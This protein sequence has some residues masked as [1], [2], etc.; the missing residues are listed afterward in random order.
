[1][2]DRLLQWG[3]GGSASL[4][5]EASSSST[6]RPLSYLDSVQ[7][8]LHT[9]N[10]LFPD[11]QALSQ[12]RN[13]QIFPLSTTP[14]TS[15]SSNVR[16]FDYSEEFELDVKDVRVIIMQDA[17]GPT[18]ASLL[19]DSHPGPDLVSASDRS[20]AYQ[21]SKATMAAA[22]N[23]SLTQTTR[24]LVIQGET[25]QPRQGAFDRRTSNHGRSQSYSETDSQKAAR[26]YREELAAFSSCI[27]GNSELMAYKGTSTKVHVVPSEFQADESAPSSI[28]GEGR[29]PIGLSQSYSSQPMSPNFRKGHNSG[30]GHSR[31]NKKRKVLITRL[32]PVSLAIDGAD[33]GTQPSANCPRL[34]TTGFPFPSSAEESA[35]QPRQRRTPMYA[36]VLV[37][38]IPPAT[39]KNS[40]DLS[41][42]SLFRRESGSYNDQDLFSSSYNST[43][44]G[45]N[46]SGFGVYADMEEAIV[47]E[48][49]IDTLTEHWDVI[50]RTLNHLQSLV[51]TTIHAM[52]KHADVASP[53]SFPCP[54]R[55]HTRST[56]QVSFMSDRR[57]GELPRAK[58]LKS[59]TK[60][61]YLWPNCLAD[62]V[63]IG[64]EVSTARS[65]II[66]GLSAARVITGQGRWG[67]W[68]D[69]AIWTSKWAASSNRTAFFQS[70]LTGFLAT[71]TDWI[72]A[73]CGPLYSKRAALARQNRTEEDSSLPARTIIISD[74]KMAARRLVFLLSAF[75]P[76]NQHACTAD[77]HRASTPASAGGYSASPPMFA[78]PSLPSL[79][80]RR[81]DVL[82]HQMKYQNVSQ[83]EYHT[84]SISQ[85]ARIWADPPQ[86]VQGDIEGNVHHQRR[87]S[88]F[89]STHSMSL[90]M[91]GKVLVSRKSSAATTSTIMPESIA[92]HFTSA[93]LRNSQRSRPGSTGSAATDDLK[94]SLRRGDRS[95]QVVDASHSLGSGRKWGGLIVGFWGSRRGELIDSIA[96]SQGSA[97][98]RSPT[99]PSF[100]RTNRRSELIRESQEEPV[101]GSM[102]A[103]RRG[104]DAR[105]VHNP[106]FSFA[107]FGGR[108]SFAQADRT[109]D[110]ASA[111]VSPIK[112]S[113]NP[114]DGV[115][116]VEV[117]LPDYLT[118]F[119]TAI[120]SPSSSGYSSAPGFSSGFEGFEQTRFAIEGDLPQN[121]A[122]WLDGFHPDFVLQALPPQD[123]LMDKV[124]AAMRAE[125][126]PAPKDPRVEV[127]A[128]RWVNVSSVVIA[129]T[130]SKAVTRIVY[131]RRVRSNA[132]PDRPVPNAFA[133]FKSSALP[134]ETRLEE[135]WLEET[136]RSG[137]ETLSDAVNR[138]VCTTGD[139]KRA[140]KASFADSSQ[141]PGQVHESSAGHST[142]HDALSEAR[143]LAKPDF[144]AAP[145]APRS[146]CKTVILSALED[147]F[148]EVVESRDGGPTDS[149]KNKRQ[150]GPGH[151]GSIL[152]DAVRDWV[153]AL[154]AVE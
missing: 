113:I 134:L 11:S 150:E 108:R 18:N 100:G 138:V 27:F 8:D 54:M 144:S 128:E 142:A 58:P 147:M 132:A 90:P 98:L 50:M 102:A 34:D 129:D 110:P 114:E 41:T 23:D 101:Y 97:E 21:D 149:K 126:T 19:F 2:L 10:L 63:G 84:R 67:I 75:L 107:S 151:G 88:D 92:P 82:R 120:G 152:R 60:L 80:L 91:H 71:H 44:T 154:D 32:F 117:P 43:K 6:P 64:S 53:D 105:D 135:D 123:N 72:Q 118:R 7:E 131:R 143:G 38:Q 49:K 69:E 51:A 93:E 115:I 103:N 73:L 30:G 66:T 81:E 130:R 46:M 96:C 15:G 74:D 106:R 125:P 94:R 4:S 62:D 104:T 77:A 26:E 87:A 45:W 36:V 20:P 52:L 140:N 40:S 68:R 13:D 16:A 153:A 89:V 139:G 116:D 35:A 24:P 79:P 136:I 3:A 112:T 33:S 121:T 109:P 70:L 12:N 61:V 29:T 141:S 39:F 148:R 28:Y 59:S 119:G 65:R 78:M 137:D 42:K 25:C 48:D 5:A 9:R 55:P 56:S 124:K 146:Q 76:A 17:L 95:R 127:I 31:R 22:G 37:V 86:L 99:K 145:N 1:M 122:G 47:K 133:T 57:G 83:Q 14:D 111:F 85:S